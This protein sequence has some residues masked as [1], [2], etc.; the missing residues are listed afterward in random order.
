MPKKKKQPKNKPPA[1]QFYVKDW[2]ASPTR[3]MMSL[4]GQGAYIN[5]L[6][7]AWDSDPI[8]TIPNQ[9]DKLWKLAGAMPEEWGLIKDEVLESFEPF[10]EDSTRLVN[11]RLR[12]QWL[13]LKEF[14]EMASDRGKKGAAGRWSKDTPEPEWA[15]EDDQTPEEAQTEEEVAIDEDAV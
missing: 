12:R 4:A 6:A 2:T 10:D 11:K 3:Q 8:A 5:L 14:S 9:P 13:E 15:E 7:V 1:F